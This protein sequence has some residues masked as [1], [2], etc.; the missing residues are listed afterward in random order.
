MGKDPSRA[1]PSQLNLPP[2][3]RFYPTDEE[4]VVHYL[5]K[6][7]ASEPFA[8]PIIAEIELYKFDPW[9]L[10]ERAL[11]GEKEWYF[12]S[13]RDRKYPNGSRP[14]RA[15]GTGYWKA[16][17]TDKPILTMAGSKKV[18]V[19]KALVFYR[20][21]APKGLKTNWIMHEYRLADS[22]ARSAK[23]KGTL[24]LD[25][26]VL[27]RI[28]KK[29]SSA[30][31][32]QKAVNAKERSE[33]SCLDNALSPLPGS[34]NRLSPN[35]GSIDEG[36]YVDE[37][38]TVSLLDLYQNGQTYPVRNVSELNLYIQQMQAAGRSFQTAADTAQKHSSITNEQ[39]RGAVSS[40]DMSNAASPSNVYSSRH[41]ASEGSVQEDVD[42]AESTFNML[43]PALAT[44]QM[45]AFPQSLYGLDAGGL[46]PSPTSMLG[47]G[48]FATL[49]DADYNSFFYNSDFNL[50]MRP[51]S[52]G[53]HLGSTWD[54]KTNFAT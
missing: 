22:A 26:W 42:A 12:F 43:P 24:R 37:K 32:A 33:S 34:H 30:A 29:F 3:F 41:T 31:G 53:S 13:P 19:K 5:C 8:I 23:K 14:N 54:A 50:Q 28:Y 18:G 48:S 4:L 11:F 7:A 46:L 6:K 38:R 36:A 35:L 39:Q 44:E 52:R 25:D 49:L 9:D 21:K 1:P 20:G 15:A 27:C 47:Q 10:P 45:N 16:T 40:A 2:G 17:G 51:F